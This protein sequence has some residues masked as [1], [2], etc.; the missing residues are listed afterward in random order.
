[1]SELSSDLGFAFPTEPLPPARSESESKTDQ[2]DKNP[3][4]NTST[5]DGTGGNECVDTEIDAKERLQRFDLVIQ[6]LHRLRATLALA[7]PSVRELQKLQ[8]LTVLGKSFPLY[9]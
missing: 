5:S 9:F 8:A 7:S 1:M 3:T 2:D 4:T 6:H